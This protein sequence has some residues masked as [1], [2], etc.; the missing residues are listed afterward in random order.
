MGQ[1]KVEKPASLCLAMS[2]TFITLFCTPE[3]EAVGLYRGCSM[4][5][6]CVYHIFHASIWHALLNL[7]CFLSIVFIY[8]V[9]WLRIIAAYIMA[10]SVPSLLLSDTPVVGL[11]AVCYALLGLHFSSVSS[12]RRIPYLIHIALYLCVGFILPAVSGFVHLYCF[13]FG[14]LMALLNTPYRCSVK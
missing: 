8:H 9:R 14:L 7:W 6:R 12:G 4:I 3:W 11:S 1:G 10:A 5:G 13:V 2:V